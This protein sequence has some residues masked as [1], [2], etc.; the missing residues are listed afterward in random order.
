[1]DHEN[2]AM[3]LIVRS[4][5]AKS[6]AMTA[7][8]LARTGDID[9]AGIKLKESDAA[10]V[11]SHEIQALALKQSLE[12]PEKGVSLLMAHAQDHLMNAI[13]TQTLAQEFI[14][15]YGKMEELAKLVKG[16]EA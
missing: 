14:M 10:M 16:G 8:S 7:I 12:D 11:E 13:T 1:M 3:Q 6:L 15:M 5:N 9:S 2:L 4:G